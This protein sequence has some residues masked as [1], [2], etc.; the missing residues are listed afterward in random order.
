MGTDEDPYQ[1]ARA[2]SHLRRHLT[3][4][5]NAD[6]LEGLELAALDLARQLFGPDVHL[7]VSRTYGVQDMAPAVP[8]WAA[9]ITI[10]EIPER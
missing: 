2:A 3:T 9:R 10:H 8:R 4:H 5:V 6:T 1:R 7:E